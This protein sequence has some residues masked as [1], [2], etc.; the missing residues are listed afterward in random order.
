VSLSDVIKGFS[1]GAEHE[2]IPCGDADYPDRVELFVEDAEFDIAHFDTVP[3]ESEDE[4][5]KYRRV[6]E[7]CK[8][9]RTEA[10]WDI[11]W[12]M[13][14]LNGTVA[15]PYEG[16]LE[17]SILR[18]CVMGHRAGKWHISGLDGKNVAE[19]C[20]WINSHNTSGKVYTSE[21]WKNAGKKARWKNILPME[22]IQDKL[23]E[24]QADEAV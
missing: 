20:R 8:V 11:F 1:E 22:V 6:R 9:L 24:L 23:T 2:V 15:Q 3:F 13:V 7:N 12:R 17:W 5:K 19:K 4:F 18:S 16:D 14:E 21:D 10:D